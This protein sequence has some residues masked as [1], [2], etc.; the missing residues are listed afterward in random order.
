MRVW[1]AFAL[2]A[3]ATAPAHATQGDEPAEVVAD[4]FL[5]VP[6]LAALRRDPR[7][8]PRATP[9][10]RKE[11]ALR[12]TDAT[13]LPP[14]IVA[15]AQ[16]VA[17]H[18]IPGALG[19][20]YRALDADPDLPLAL[21]ELGV[22]YFRMQRYGDAL[23]A[24]E[25]F[26]EVVPERVGDTRALGHCYYSLGRYETARDHYTRVLAAAPASVEALRGL[27]LSW[28]RLGDSARALELLTRVLT[29]DPKHADAQ[30]WV[31]QILY[32]QEQLEPALAAAEKARALA[33]HLPRA[34]FLLGQIHGELGHAAESRDALKRYEFLAHNAQE[35]RAL[36][37]RLLLDPGP[38]D[39]VCR[40]VELYRASGDSAGARTWIRRALDDA[41]ASYTVRKLALESF[42]AL[43]DDKAAAEAARALEE[44]FPDEAETWRLLE[45][46]FKRVGDRS[47]QLRAGERARRL[48][49]R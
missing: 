43:G 48:G 21:H 40:L 6:R 47:N 19:E 35:I 27:A 4:A 17:R 30:M 42:D 7:G 2:A 14:A 13:Q 46:H 45:N 39:L 8:L 3:F 41:P 11:L 49:G 5:D 33:P 29:L 28:M 15:A 9:E 32:D 24:F 26:L 22:L 37:G 25:R 31:A 38:L 10:R 1:C 44:R 16:L 36:E 23:V 18:D 34:W 12:A 20:L